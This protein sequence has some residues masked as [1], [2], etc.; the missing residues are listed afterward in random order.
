MAFYSLSTD[1]HD[2]KASHAEN[3]DLKEY[4]ENLTTKYHLHPHLTFN[5]EVSSANWDNEA[6]QYNISL[7]NVVTGE[8]TKTTAEV[9]IS[10][11][12]VLENPRYIDIPG[13]GDFQGKIFHSA[14]WDQS[15]ELRGKRVG[16]VGN[17]ASA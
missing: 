12:G 10:A 14:R 8:E 1:L 2:W 17:G 4:W 6:Q 15:V 16:V 11:I 7:R 9:L 5:T 13:V 3:K